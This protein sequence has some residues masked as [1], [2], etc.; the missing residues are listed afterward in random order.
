M[1]HTHPH[2]PP[3]PH[4]HTRTQRVLISTQGK[5]EKGALISIRSTQTRSVLVNSEVAA[6]LS[7]GIGEVFS[8]N[9]IVYV[10]N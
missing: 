8:E 7:A 4:T 6:S 3:N 9:T 5:L 1:T 2:P 10:S